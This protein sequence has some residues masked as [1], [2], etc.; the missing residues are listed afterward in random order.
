MSVN[1]FRS[2]WEAVNYRVFESERVCGPVNL[3]CRFESLSQHFKIIGTLFAFQSCCVGSLSG[4]ELLSFGRPEAVRCPCSFGLSFGRC[5]PMRPPGSGWCWLAAS[6]LLLCF[7]WGPSDCRL[8]RPT[9][10]HTPSSPTFI[11]CY[12]SVDCY[13]CLL[14]TP[15]HYGCYWIRSSCGGCGPARQPLHSSSHSRRSD[16]TVITLSYFVAQAVSWGL[17]SCCTD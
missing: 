16:S 10:F 5:W 3:K 8:Q 11:P 13:C 6:L 2:R 12:C 17:D 15:T 14:L 4:S 1:S 7:G 9:L